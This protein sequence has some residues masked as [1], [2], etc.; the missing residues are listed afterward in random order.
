MIC[1]DFVRRRSLRDTD[2]SWVFVERTHAH[3][4]HV[5]FMLVGINNNTTHNH[6]LKEM[7]KRLTGLYR[8]S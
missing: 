5:H 3:V 8:D 6:M 2:G 4:Q 7:W 1:V